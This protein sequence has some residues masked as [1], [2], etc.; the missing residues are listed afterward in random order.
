M[1][2]SVSNGFPRK[3]TEVQTENTGEVIKSS[4]T[5]D[6]LFLRRGTRRLREDSSNVKGNLMET[7]GLNPGVLTRRKGIPVWLGLWRKHIMTS[8]PNV[9]CAHVRLYSLTSERLQ[10]KWRALVKV[11]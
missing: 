9:R 1:D 7:N 8:Y 11:K 3:W 2:H 6:T 4:V 10:E 5:G